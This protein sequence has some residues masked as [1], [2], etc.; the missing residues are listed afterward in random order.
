MKLFSYVVARDYGFA[1]NPFFGVC[2]LATCKPRI[3]KAATIGDWV[4]GT[5][6]KKNDRQGVLVYAMGVSEVMMFNEYWSDERFLRKIPNLRGSKK[7]A[8]G[9]NIYYRNSD[10]QWHQAESHHSYPGRPNPHNIRNDTQ[11]DRVLIGEEFGYW[12]GSG[13]EIPQ[14]FRDYHGADICA[15]RNHKNQFP[16]E[17]VTEFIE[18]F[19]SL[20]QTG[21]QGK[22]LDWA[23]TP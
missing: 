14:K 13:P 5:G 17:L 1:P 15:G 9:D 2:T 7:Q 21:Y 18:W 10:G 16:D 22:S 12:G 3:R 6:S 23:R 11:T 4:I 8:F 19:R 20:K